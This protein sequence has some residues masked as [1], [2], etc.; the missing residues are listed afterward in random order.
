M[1]GAG[2]TEVE[3][4]ELTSGR[5][6]Y[7]ERRVACRCKG[8]S[9]FFEEDSARFGE[10]C[11]MRDSTQ[12]CC[13]QFCFQ[14]LDLL[15]EG[16]LADSKPGS[17]PCEIQFLGNRDEVPDV[18]QFQWSYPLLLVCGRRAWLKQTGS[19]SKVSSSKYVNAQPSLYVNYSTSIGG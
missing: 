18:T 19:P 8:K 9:P 7:G 3:A 14:I 15:A 13:A 4:T 2:E 11:S 5:S 17:S 6:L 12:Q 1:C 16:W 10:L